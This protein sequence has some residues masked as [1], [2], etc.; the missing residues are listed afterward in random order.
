MKKILVVDDN[1]LNIRLLTEILQDE[2]YDVSSVNNSLEVMEAAHK[3]K[4][5]IILLDIMMPGID[6]FAVCKLLKNDFDL[7][8]IPVIMVTAKTDGTDVK[9]ALEL[10]AFDYIKK[11]VDEDEVVAR[12]QSALRL[13]E[14]QDKLKEMAMKDGLTG[15]YNHSLLIELFRKEFSKQQR[16]HNPLSFVMIDIDH[17]KK[18]NDTHGH[19]AGDIVLKEL[20]VILTN[21]V[22]LSDIVGRYGGEEFGIVLPEI[23]HRDSYL[24]CER[25]RYNVENTKFT[26]QNNPIDITVSIGICHKEPVDIIS[27][28]EMIK[29]ADD[30]L[31]TAKNKGRNRIEIYPPVA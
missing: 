5:D 22:R 13:K 10:G 6:G 20:S 21:S 8:D 17:F 16:N 24:L 2:N 29:N 4:P 15:L 27:C 1:R 11:P 26:S 9:M 28:S 30:A 18:I 19:M 14:Y 3:F 23:G 25:I 7:K 12:V 31:Y